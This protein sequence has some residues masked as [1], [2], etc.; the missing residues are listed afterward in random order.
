MASSTGPRRRN[1]EEV[2]QAAETVL[3]RDG[4]P[5]LTMT[6]L[7]EEL[8]VKVPSLY[9]HVPNLEALCGELQNRAV[10]DLGLEL[11]NAAMGKT[12]GRA[13]RAMAEAQR[14]FALAHPGRYDLATRAHID[15]EGF[16]I[17]SVDA[18]AA[19]R[20]V[21]A[22]YGLPD[23]DRAHQ[24]TFFASLHGVL[25]LEVAGFFDD[26][27]DVDAIFE[28]VLRAI[29]RGLDSLDLKEEAS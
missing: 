20:A 14:A 24:L 1:R 17:A 13:L 7:A 2:L 18:A 16:A 6:S 22:S 28:R 21:M 15:P 4:W 19:L 27:V 23:G 11:R 25:A 9:N 8:G 29:L 5:A 3:D 26:T 12:R 10:Q